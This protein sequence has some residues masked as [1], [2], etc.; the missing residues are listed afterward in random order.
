MVEI[1]ELR[2]D[3]IEVRVAH[4]KPPSAD[5]KGG[6]QL[7]LYKDARCDM[8]IL[9]ETFGN[10]GWQRHHQILG[11][12]IYCTVSIWDGE[13]WIDKMDAGAE[14]YTE[15]E[16]GAASDSFKR[17]CTNV[18][19]GRSL[20]T[21][22]FI[23]VSDVDI[24][25]KRDGKPYCKDKFRVHTYTVDDGKIVQLAIYRERDNQIVYRYGL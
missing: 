23:W 6:V 15:K 1:R 22:P 8:R 5:S 17:A 16:K 18:G 10:N 24:Q 3:E 20:Y 7:L 9:D 11:D 13:Q 4:I 14:S 19:I 2:A 12:T 21:S 25:I